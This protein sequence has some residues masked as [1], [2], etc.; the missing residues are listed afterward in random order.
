MKKKTEKIKPR[1]VGCLWIRNNATDQE[2]CSPMSWATL[3]VRA[4]LFD[5]EPTISWDDPVDEMAPVATP[6]VKKAKVTDDHL[7]DL[8]R[9]VHGNLHSRKFLVDEFAAFRQKHYG[10][11]EDFVE[12]H[13]VASKIKEISE[14]R[15]ISQDGMPKCSGW[16]VKPEVL[17]KFQLT[18]LPLPNA[19]EYTLTPTRVMGGELTAAGSPPKKLNK[20]VDDEGMKDLIRLLHGNKKNRSFL[21]KEFAAFRQKT[22]G[23]REN[24]QEFAFINSTIKSIAEWKQCTVEGPMKGK[25]GWWVKPE[26]LEKYNLSDLP[27]PN[28]WTYTLEHVPKHKP[29]P[30]LEASSQAEKQPAAVGIEKFAKVLSKPATP[31]PKKRVQLLMSVPRGQD[32]HET[33]KN[34]LISQFLNKTKVDE[35]KTPITEASPIP[36]DVDAV[37]E[38]D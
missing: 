16:W 12:L 19:W 37:I 27:V 32:F 1:L 4:M 18:D 29:A 8:I 33:K 34:T 10:E 23:H 36:M 6:G 22:Y 20:K 7:P 15:Q 24:F 21:V 26:I 31:Q 11:Q 9:L 30:P 5:G 13:Q 17:E 28:T 35:Q 14:Y 38:L 25:F 3:Q 2:G